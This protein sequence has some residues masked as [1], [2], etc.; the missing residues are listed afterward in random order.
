[1]QKVFDFLENELCLKENDV[2]VLG[3]SYGPDSMAL[4]SLLIRLKKALDIEVVCA[5]VNHNTGRPGQIKE[6]QFV[7]KFCRNNG[8]VFETMI[9]EDYGDDNF[10]NE[11][12]TK[13]YNFF[14]KLVKQ[15]NAKYLFTAHHGDDL[16][17][18]ILMR[19]VRGS[20]LRG[21][22]GFS[23]VV[24]KG[25]YKK[26]RPL[27]NLTKEE[28]LEYNRKNKIPYAIDTSNQKD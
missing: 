15:Y 5:H 17:E 10:H 8:V 21:Y 1:M 3:N 28:I 16:M 27:I 20:T 19:I 24:N 22:S 7:E 26:V 25:N 4:L 23:Q 12:H 18:T 11:A 9:I 2:I 14:H 13:R 6:Q